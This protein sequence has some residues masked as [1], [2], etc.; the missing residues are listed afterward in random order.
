MKSKVFESLV[1]NLVALKTRTEAVIE[2]IFKQLLK[3]VGKSVCRHF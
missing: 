3:D 2:G 1:N